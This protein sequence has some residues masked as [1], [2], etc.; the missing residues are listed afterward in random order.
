VRLRSCSN[1]T[2]GFALVG[3]GIIAVTPTPAAPPTRYVP[4]IQLTS[5][6]D[7]DVVIDVIRHG[8]MISPFEDELTGS[9][10]YPGAPLSELGQQQAQDVA[11]QLFNELGQHVAGIFSGQGTREMETAAPF[12]ALENASGNVQILPGLDEID[13]GI[14]AFDPID[15]P[16][17]QLAFLTA[18]AWSLGSPF[19]LAL[20]QA[21]GSSDVNGVVF[22]AKFTDAIDTM[23]GDAV[24]NPVVSADG[25]ITD[26]AFNSEASIFVWTLDNV[27]NPDL[28][29]FINRIIEAH[30]VPNG[31][32]T[33]LLPNTGVVQIEGN[34]TDGWTL[35]SWDGQAI[36]Q[37]PDLLSSLFVDLRDVALPEQTA[38]WNIWEAVL[39]GD[40]TTIMNAVQTGFDNVDSALAQF[41][42][43]IVNSIQDAVTNLAATEA[44][45]QA[46]MSLSDLVAAL[47]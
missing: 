5:G 10:S 4:T 28:P 19:G 13:S 43:S 11:N 38:E 14:Y 45:A 27:K 31:L 22:D 32:S 33:V 26:V 8:Q 42:E 30:T 16:G 2:A 21:P 20:V 24:A 25:Q 18:G 44:G 41:P 34:P 39:G 6:G 15:S 17:G 36:P 47:F 7:P 23:Y 12:A 29:F 35:I 9:P 1:I 46:G 37:N 40:P 3:A